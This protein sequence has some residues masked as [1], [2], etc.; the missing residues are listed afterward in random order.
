MKIALV[1]CGKMGRMVE[2]AAQRRGITVVARFTREQP[3]RADEGAR[4]TLREAPVLVDFSTPAAVLDNIRAAA[5]LSLNIVVGTTG[6]HHHLEEARQAVAKNNTGLVYGSNF[7]LGVNL[8]YQ[9]VERAA[10]LFSAFD[11]YE[12]FIQEAH[13]KFKKDAPSGTAL[14]LQKLLAEKYAPREVPVASTRA[15]HIP[16]THTVSFDS[17]VDTISLEHVARNREGFAEGALLAAQWIAG[18][19]G[20]YEFRELLQAEGPQ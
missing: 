10:Q 17:P 12:A 20:F 5:G 19:K 18:R 4:Q 2:A 16:G 1:G 7:S 9:L 15:G 3:L 8:F 14:V 6:W 13:H 11:Q